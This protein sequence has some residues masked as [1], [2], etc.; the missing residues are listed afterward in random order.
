MHEISFWVSLRTPPLL[1]PQL[2]QPREH[3]PQQQRAG[4]APTSPTPPEPLLSLGTRT[5]ADCS[6]LIP[7]PWQAEEGPRL[8]SAAVSSLH[9]R[10]S[11]FP[12]IPTESH[13]DRARGTS[14]MQPFVS[15][16]CT[17]PHVGE[18]AHDQAAPAHSLSSEEEQQHSLATWLSSRNALTGKGERLRVQIQ[19]DVL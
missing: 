19:P 15:G 18:Q 9:A 3:T 16:R 6:L 4:S 8:S 12:L 2:S 11:A 14:S 17:C 10:V 13:L 5:R 1:Q 7:P